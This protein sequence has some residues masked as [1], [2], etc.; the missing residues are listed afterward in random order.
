MA[1]PEKSSSPPTKR[2]FEEIVAASWKTVAPFWP[3][4]DFVAVNPL[5]GVEELPFEEAF[6]QS[7]A[8]FQKKTCPQELQAANRATIKWLQAYFYEGQ[9]A[10]PMPGRQKGLYQ[11]WRALA[12]YDA[13]IHQGKKERIS[14]LSNL[15]CDP[16]S[17]LTLALSRLRIEEKDRSLFL[18]LLL[19]SL[20]G[21]AG[22]VKYQALFSK[23]AGTH[24]LLE[25]M[26]LRASLVDLLFPDA[27]SL[28]TRYRDALQRAQQERNP[29]EEMQQRE[30][31][32]RSNLLSRLQTN[33]LPKK[34]P[35][36][37]FVFCIDTRSEPFRR[38]LE[39]TGAYETFGFAGFFGIPLE[40]YDPITD[41]TYASCPPL[42]EAKHR[43]EKVYCSAQKA[44]PKRSVG[45]YFRLMKQIYRS[46]KYTF[47]TPFSLV[48]FLGFFAGTW[49]ALRTWAP[50]QSSSLENL[51]S[52]ALGKP[53]DYRVDAH[54][55][56]LQEQC[57]YAENML[58]MIGLT[59]NFAPQVFLSAHGSETQNN[60]HASS[61]DCGACGGHHGDGNA[62]LLAQICNDPAV[63]SYLKR[64][65]IVIPE[66]TCF[67]A[68]KHNTTTDEMLLYSDASSDLSKVRADL[69]KAQKRAL[70]LRKKNSP[71]G[72]LLPGSAKRRATNWAEVR[73]EWGLA[74]NAAFVVGPR[75]LTEGI[76]LEGRCFLHSYEPEKDPSGAYLRTILTA[77]MV[78]AHW[79]SAQYLFSTLDPTAFGAGSK[80]TQNI[81]GKIGVMQ[82]NASDLMTGLSLQSLYEG[83]RT[84]HHVPQRLLTV[85][86]G[87][88]SFI[89]TIVKEESAVRNLFKNGWVDLVC[90]EPQ[91][92]SSYS[93]QRD[94]TWLLQ[95]K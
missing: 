82:G 80:V 46:V 5:L 7:R 1:P 39:S 48:E 52:E 54:S 18:S 79:I 12:P 42:L 21:W 10:F 28:L 62:K 15:P 49:T 93:L 61:L 29:L 47:V 76:N 83:D 45:T 26:A 24:L 90:I 87:K 40:L 16:E 58:R 32:Y 50:K 57:I 56:P 27:Q 43:V 11:S 8:H 68:A 86:Y 69:E 92:G 88:R 91:L 74:R 67:F 37:Q 25:Y 65:S 72:G 6:A 89:D 14:L 4:E 41:K 30:Q 31:E 36:A 35:I 19:G 94:L 33:A 9:A 53:K 22:Y 70:L 81:V 13:Q 20:P 85:V 66:N 64:A 34:S 17:A 2:P 51:F 73:P 59:D 60:P 84:P 71:S 78:V 44:G 63:R 3:L 55:I 23:R 95:D 75:R 38:A 77:P